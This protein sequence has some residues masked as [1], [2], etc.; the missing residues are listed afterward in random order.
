LRYEDLRAEPILWVSQ[1]F[2]WAGL[3]QGDVEAIVTRMAFER[4]PAEQI[5]EGQF[6]R[7]G[8]PGSWDE[9]LTPAEARIIEEECAGQM[10]RYGYDTSADLAQPVAALG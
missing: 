9:T 10:Q 1:A 8:K 2:A 7:K 4:A 6:R 5:G 3:P